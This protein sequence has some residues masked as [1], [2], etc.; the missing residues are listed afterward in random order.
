MNSE[1]N[2]KTT[3]PEADCPVVRDLM[4]ALEY[5]RYACE[6]AEGKKAADRKML[7]RAMSV[8]TRVV[9][10]HKDLLKDYQMESYWAGVW[11]SPAN[12]GLPKV[13]RS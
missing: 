10:K 9:A 12:V 5:L 13:T 7:S 8:G 6:H 3:S 11:E 4:L 2:A 1:N